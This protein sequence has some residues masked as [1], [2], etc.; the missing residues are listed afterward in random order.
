MLREL[1]PQHGLLRLRS[2]DRAFERRRGG[3]V[4]ATETARRGEGER[5]GARRTHLELEEPG[6][7]VP[8]ELSQRLLLDL[9]T[10]EHVLGGRVRGSREL[11]L[12]RGRAFGV[13]LVRAYGSRH[14]PPDV[15]ADSPKTHSSILC[16]E[17]SDPNYFYYFRLLGRC[18]YK[19]E[20]KK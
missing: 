19:N 8:S 9:Q 4:S 3:G 16:Y 10:G 13:A 5:A 18:F 1:V 6:E 15:R 7:E 12:D 11:A 2:V 20:N 14:A 17:D